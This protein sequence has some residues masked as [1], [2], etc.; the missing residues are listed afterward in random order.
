MAK[1]QVN[2]ILHCRNFF[3]YVLI[4]IPWD[5]CIQSLE[6]DI[7]RDIKESP[8]QKRGATKKATRKSI[9]RSS[10]LKISSSVHRLEKPAQARLKFYFTDFSKEVSGPEIARAKNHL[11]ANNWVRSAPTIEQKIRQKFHQRWHEL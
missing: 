9:K 3:S 2:E 10:P 1:I 4:M 7:V 6:F 8:Q 11:Q 5:F